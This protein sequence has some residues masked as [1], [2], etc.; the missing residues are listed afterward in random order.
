MTY[1]E[2]LRGHLLIQHGLIDNNVHANNTWQLVGALRKASKPVDVTIYPQSDHSLGMA[3]FAERIEY[4]REHLLGAY[5][6]EEQADDD[7]LPPAESIQ[8]VH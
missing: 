8:T 4:L 7:Q 1:A 5:G 2:N 3:A 6:V